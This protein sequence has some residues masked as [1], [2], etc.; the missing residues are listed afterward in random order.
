VASLTGHM[1]SPYFSSY[2][3]S[4]AYIINFG[5]S[6]RSELREKGVTI[7]VLSPGLTSTPMSETIG[8]DIDWSKTPM[9]LMTTGEVAKEAMQQFGKKASIIPGVSNRITSFFATRIAPQFFGKNNEKM[10]RKAFKEKL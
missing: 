3:A 6:L 5:L 8:K 4:K 10:M 1:I 7:S 2:A 9:K